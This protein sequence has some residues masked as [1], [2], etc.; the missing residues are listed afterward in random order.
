MAPVSDMG[1]RRA[2]DDATRGSAI[3]LAAEVLSRLVTLATT[4]LL[5]RG[6]G[7]TG[8]GTFGTLAAYAL[9][10]AEIGE[11]G[12]QNLASRALVD[13]TASLRSLLRARLVAAGLAAAVAL[14]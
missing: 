4:F 6:L 1:A 10:L 12:L 11:L 3:K 7:A 14:A 2:A 8:F 9:L 5:M 13:G